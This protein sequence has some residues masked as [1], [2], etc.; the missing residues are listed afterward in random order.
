MLDFEREVARFRSRIQ[1]A[2]PKA[3]AKPKTESGGGRGAHQHL[4]DRAKA[5]ATDDEGFQTA[6]SRKRQAQTWK[7][8][9]LDFNAPHIDHDDLAAKV[10][11]HDVGT[12]FKYVV[13]VHDK[14]QQE[15]ADSLVKQMP[16]RACL[17]VL[18][19]KEGVME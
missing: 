10:T 4:N 19:D 12:L 17:I 14:E 2:A 15:F 18:A 11:A 1:A 8:R 6:I 3:K 13:Q 16:L 9:E 5:R 7:M